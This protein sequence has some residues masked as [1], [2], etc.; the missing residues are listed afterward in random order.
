M[1]KQAKTDGE[2][3]GFATNTNAV[4][5]RSYQAKSLS[6]LHKMCNL[7]T[8]LNIYK[9]T[10]PSYI[11]RSGDMVFKVINTFK[12]HYITHSIRFCEEKKTLYN[13]SSDAK[14]PAE[15]TDYLLLLNQK[16]KDLCKDFLPRRILTTTK[17]FM[18]RSREI[19]LKC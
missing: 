14:L 18:I 17:S 3:K 19:K 10:R 9:K 13:L 8:T 4:A 7:T 2:K 12:N 1:N 5:N 6:C 11:L 15:D 16:G